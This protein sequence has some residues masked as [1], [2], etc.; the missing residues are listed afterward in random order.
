MAKKFSCICNKCKFKYEVTW[1]SNG[2]VNFYN[3]FCR[4]CEK[5]DTF[6]VSFKTSPISEK[7]PKECLFCKSESIKEIED[8][9]TNDET[10]RKIKHKC[11][12][13]NSTDVTKKLKS[14]IC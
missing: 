8:D 11:P 10:N 4:E 9:Y 6:S 1:G 12:K 5:I 2:V 3:F 14:V 13:C 7:M